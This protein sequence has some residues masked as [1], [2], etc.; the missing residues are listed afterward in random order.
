MEK[1]K[2]EKKKSGREENSGKTSLRRVTG[3]LHYKQEHQNLMPGAGT[4]RKSR[5]QCDCFCVPPS[6]TGRI[7]ITVKEN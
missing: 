3:E 1:D 7:T 4:L 5:G 6:V 2:K